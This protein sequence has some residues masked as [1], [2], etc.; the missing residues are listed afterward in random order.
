MTPELIPR[1][2]F[3]SDRSS[4]GKSTLSQLFC[5]WAVRQGHRVTAFKCGPDFLDTQYLAGASGR[6]AYNLDPW[7]MDRDANLRCLAEATRGA[8]LAVLEGAMGLFDGKRGQPFGSASTAALAAWTQSP[9]VVV[10]DARKAGQSLAVTALGLQK[11]DPT[12]RLAGVLFN[13]ASSEAH[14]NLLAKAVAELCGLP[15]FGWLPEEAGRMVGERHLGLVALSEQGNYEKQLEDWLKTAEKSV[16][17]QAILKTTF[18]VSPLEVCGKSFS[19]LGGSKVKIA[20]ARDKAFHFYY[21]QN[22]DLLEQAGADLIPFS[23][24]KDD[25]LPSDIGGLLIGGG[26]PELFGSQLQQQTSLRAKVCEAVKN[27]MPTWAECGGLMW[28]CE[29]LTDLQGRSFEMAGVLPARTRMEKKLVNFGY[30][31]VAAQRDTVLG[32]AG[33]SWRGHEFHHSRLEWQGTPASSAWT[34]QQEGRSDRREGYL[35]PKGMA[36]YLHLHLG[37]C[38]EVAG[39]FV[40][41]CRAYGRVTA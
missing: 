14:A 41:A 13:R 5:L 18:E 27:G 10:L 33:S 7:M 28:L 40:D 19:S 16:D 1:I 2:L 39:R 30:T 3:S 21:Q 22:L 23:P 8:D 4:A 34:L 35:L 24:L 9:V 25:R 17:F 6:P 38:P 32:P 26:F 11:A 37:G 12:L 29:S 20:I 31:A 15:S 36:T